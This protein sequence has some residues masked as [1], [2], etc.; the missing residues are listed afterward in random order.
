MWYGGEGPDQPLLVQLRL[1]EP[2]VKH[3]FSVSFGFHVWVASSSDHGMDAN[4]LVTCVV[5]EEGENGGTSSV[6]SFPH[7]CARPADDGL[8]DWLTTFAGA[9]TGGFKCIHKK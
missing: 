9:Q 4:A 6:H 8:P 2:E 1:T 5:S 3:D 7:I